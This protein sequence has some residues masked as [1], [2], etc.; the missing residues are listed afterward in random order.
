MLLASVVGAAE[1]LAV[2]S[3]LAALVVV[4]AIGA[5][6]A[7]VTGTPHWAR[8]YQ[9]ALALGGMAAAA[10]LAFPV[11]V[12]GTLALAAFLGLGMGLFVGMLAAGLAES[13]AALPVLG[14]RLG[15]RAFL[16]R[17]VIALALGK[18]LG[19]V[20]AL[21]VPGLWVRPPL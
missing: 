3:G 12:H 16:P 20:A 9:W 18:L 4:L 8:R 19:A 5:R 13:V 17:L 21:A 14:R 7:A 2:G 10:A 15:L 11:H 1:G 6:L